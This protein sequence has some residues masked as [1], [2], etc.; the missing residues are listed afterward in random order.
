MIRIRR[1]NHDPDK[2]AQ[3]LAA[4][5]LVIVDLET[6][7]L[8]RYD[9]I[10][11][12]G[13]L[14]DRDAH[15]II[16]NEHH[17]LSSLS[18]QSTFDQLRRALP[19][20]ADRR[21]LIAVFHNAMFD[22]FMLERAGITVNCIIHDTLKLIKLCDSDRGSEKTNDGGTRTQLPRHERRHETNLTYRLKDLAKH[23][24]NLEPIDFPGNPAGLNAATLIRYLKSDLL[25]THGL[26]ELLRRKLGPRYWTYNARL[27]AP[28]TPILV[29]MSLLGVQ[30]D[31]SFIKS[32]S[33][34]LLAI[35]AEISTVHATQFG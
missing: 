5:S 7:G 35:M 10:V 16:T 34:R 12:A 11:A 14:V 13:I 20:L 33:Q 18:L 23:V 32:E 19:P 29:D 24:L 30:A 28:I 25:I 3:A 6:T 31:P 15:I 9:R 21:D 26:Y 4:A 22:V 17:D 1:T 2:C 8:S 27:I